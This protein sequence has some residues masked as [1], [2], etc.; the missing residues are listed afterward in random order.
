MN[1]THLNVKQKYEFYNLSVLFSFL[2]M[3]VDIHE[4]KKVLKDWKSSS[5]TCIFAHIQAYK[6]PPTHP[7]THTH[8]H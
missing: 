7:H 8:T 5:F 1:A 6:R 4:L 2:H 3:A